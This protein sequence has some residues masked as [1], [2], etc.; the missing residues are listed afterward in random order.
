MRRGVLHVLGS[1]GMRVYHVL[2]LGCVPVLTQHD[3]T[4][5]AVAQAFEPEALDWNSFAVVVRRDQI[6]QLPQLL[7]KVDLREKQATLWRMV[8]NLRLELVKGFHDGTVRM[9]TN[10]VG[11]LLLL[12]EKQL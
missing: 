6:D 12:T 3:G 2:T 7:E 11:M 4:H 9:G 8:R 1:W 10:T 5:P